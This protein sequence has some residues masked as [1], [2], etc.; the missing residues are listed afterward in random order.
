MPGVSDNW[1]RRAHG[2][3]W[4]V[5]LNREG[6]M[7]ARR[8]KLK[9]GLEQLTDDELRRIIDHRSGGGSMVYDRWNYE[10]STGYY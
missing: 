6:G 3:L 2:H 5:P 7:D 8:E 1:L 10:E 4:G 9:R